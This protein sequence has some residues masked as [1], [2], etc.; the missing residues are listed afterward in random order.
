MI[1]SRTD[2]ARPTL[3]VDCYLDDPGSAQNFLPSLLGHDVEVVRPTREL[4]PADPTAYEAVILTGSSASV[5]H[6]PPDWL[7]RLEALVAS[8]VDRG[9][10]LLGVCFGHQVLASAL[11][12]RDALFTRPR[13]EIGWVD[14]ELDE[15]P[16]HHGFGGSVRSF[17]THFDEVRSGLV[18]LTVTARSEACPVHGLRVDGKPAWSVQF[19]PEMRREEAEALVRRRAGVAP[20]HIP[21][22]DAVLAG[23][24]DLD[25]DRHIRRLIS[26]FF[27]AIR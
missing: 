5:V 23:A 7:A 4:L 18:G 14:I 17:V 26:N 10:P 21:D 16:M 19:H 2:M 6:E 27:V 3:L 15:G 9:V 12:G 20:D 8:T 11:H 24:P 1:R 25:D 22:P 13:I